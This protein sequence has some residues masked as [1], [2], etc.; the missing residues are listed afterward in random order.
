[1]LCLKLCRTPSSRYLQEINNMK[2][3]F[4]G[5]LAAALAI[6]TFVLPGS[7]HA[8]QAVTAQAPGFSILET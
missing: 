4:V 7:V 2:R 3:P 6:S 8:A 5:A 1:L